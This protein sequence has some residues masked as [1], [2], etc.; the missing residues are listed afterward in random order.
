MIDNTLLTTLKTKTRLLN[1]LEQSKTSE[2]LYQDVLD[3][4]YY[5]L[6]LLELQAELVDFQKWV[7]KE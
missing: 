1:Y 3:K 7:Q 5:E 4:Y 6:L 2:P